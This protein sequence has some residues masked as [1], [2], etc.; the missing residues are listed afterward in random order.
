MFDASWNYPDAALM[1]EV[2]FNNISAFYTKTKVNYQ[3][4]R[5]IH[6]QGPGN[7]TAYNLNF[8]NYYSS[9][10]DY[11]PTV[12]ITSSQIWVPNDNVEQLFTFDGATFSLQN[13]SFNIPLVNGVE[14]SFLYSIYR[15]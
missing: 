4:P 5:I 1:N 11:K 10:D 6:Y 3:W 13:Y 15:K 7:I 14:M 8:T 9:Y 2:I 12:F